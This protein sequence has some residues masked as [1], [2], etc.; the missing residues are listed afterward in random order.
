MLNIPGAKSLNEDLI[1]VVR[2]QRHHG[3][4]LVIST[5]EPG[6]LTEL[7]ALCS[8]AVIHRFSSPEWLNVLKKHMP[9]L[10]EN[11][12]NPYQEIESLRT[13]TAL[14]YSSNAVL[15]KSGNGDLLRGASCLLKVSVRKR[16]TADGG[17]TVLCVD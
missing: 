6:L 10:C 12:E 14:M 3:V 15:G 5:Q 7:I 13:G 4:R 16:V 2:L 9:I 11:K 17:R 8:I 1:R